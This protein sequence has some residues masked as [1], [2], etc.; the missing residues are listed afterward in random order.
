MW[1]NPTDEAGQ[2]E[3]NRLPGVCGART[4]PCLV[5]GRRNALP[6][7]CAARGSCAA[8]QG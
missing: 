4:Y 1:L 2:L 3:R 8:A 5:F 7:A 6:G